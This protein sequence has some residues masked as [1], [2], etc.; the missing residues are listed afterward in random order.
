M[1]KSSCISIAVE[2]I[3][4]LENFRA[5]A[6]R[7]SAGIITIGYGTTSI[8]GRKVSMTEY[9]TEAQAKYWLTQRVAE[10]F[11]QLQAFCFFHDVKLNDNQTAAVLSFTYNVGF[12]AFKNSSMARDLLSNKADKVANDL[13]QWNKIRVKE[14]LIYSQGLY[15]RRLQEAYL[16]SRNTI[17]EV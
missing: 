6:Y 12:L 15:N 4:K 2:L 9:C 16:F 10:D 7:D 11:N 14:K 1:D 13:L 5:N 3:A 17:G 8:D